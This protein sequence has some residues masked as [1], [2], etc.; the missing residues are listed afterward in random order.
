MFGLFKSHHILLLAQ[1]LIDK[2]SISRCYFVHLIINLLLE[3][4]VGKFLQNIFG[5]DKVVIQLLFVGI[6]DEG[7]AATYIEIN[8]W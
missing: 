7:V 6:A 1:L 4:L 3:V 8:V 2:N 5:M